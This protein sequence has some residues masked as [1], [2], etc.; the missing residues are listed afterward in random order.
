MLQ[1]GIQA[2]T[3]RSIKLN[4]KYLDLLKQLELIDPGI[5]V[6][7]S[8]KKLEECVHQVLLADWGRRPY[9]DYWYI[10]QAED[11]LGPPVPRQLEIKRKL[12]LGGIRRFRKEVSELKIP[13][14]PALVFPTRPLKIDEIGLVAPSVLSNPFLLRQAILVLRGVRVSSPLNIGSGPAFNSNENEIVNFE[15][16]GGL[17]KSITVA[18]TS[19]ET[20]ACQW[21][22]ASKGSPDRSLPRYNKLIQLVNQILR[23]TKHPNYIVFPELSIPLRW[24]LR[25]SRKLAMNNVSL[26]AGVEY[27]Q[28]RQLKRLR[29]DC[30]VSLV[31]NWPG[32]A[33]SISRLQPKFVPA[34]GEKASLKAL[35]LGKKSQLFQPKGILLKPTVYK[36]KGFCFSVL[37]CSDLTNIDHRHHIRGKIDAL[38]ALEWNQDTKTFASLVEASSNDL[39][40]YVIQVNNRAYGDSRIRA[41]AKEDYL[42]DLVQ[43]KGGTIDYYVLGEVDYLALRKEQRKAS[44]KARFKPVPIGYKMSEFRKK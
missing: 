4:R 43:V 17:K 36:H 6:P 30:L 7:S 9:K 38:F 19:F 24:A 35:N 16:P 28:D 31:T 34:Y 22:N 42:R 44:K 8:L 32:Y 40:A 37:I 41:P 26:I 11:E 13:H 23:E 29:N 14:W 3:E 21:E 39:H 27:H 20:T 33:S 1:V 25:I 15:V 5:S 10:S 18:L 2:A 12:R